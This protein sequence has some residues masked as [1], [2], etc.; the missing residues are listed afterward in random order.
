MALVAAACS[1]NGLDD[2]SERA[3]TS[4]PRTTEA[5]TSTTEA[6]PPLPPVAADSGFPADWQPARLKWSPCDED[7]DAECAT[8]AVPLDWSQP[9][10]AQIDLALARLPATGDRIGSL[11]SNPGGP[12]ASGIQY[13]L[14][15]PFGDALADRFDLVSWDPRGIGASTKLSCGD[16]VGGFL[17]LD[18]DPDNS[19]EQVRLDQAAAAVAA[20]CGA[21][22]A[23]L[24]PHLGTDEVARDLEAIRLALGDPRLN[25]IGFSYG[26]LIGLRYLDLFG[27]RARAMV[28]DGVVDPTEDLVDLLSGQSAAIDAAVERIFE[29]CGERSRCPMTDPAA[30]FDSLRTEVETTPLPADHEVGPAELGTAGIYSVYDPDLWQ[31]FLRAIDQGTEGDGDA[32]WELAEGYYDFGDFTA[33]AAITCQDS[34]HPTGAEAHAA[35]VASLKVSSPRFGGNIGNEMLPCAYWPTPIDDVTGPVTAEDSPDVVVL[36]N[37]GDAL[38]PYDDS[39]EVAEM[40][41]HGNLVTYHGEGHTSYGRDDCV[42][43]AVHAYFIDLLVPPTDPQCGQASSVA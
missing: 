26:T 17:E 11:L 8:L 15:Q 33:Y 40:L 18:P 13:L 43:R 42:D 20:E 12:G 16:E 29:S 30:S 34:P 1:G 7:E 27:E 14:S 9:A 39:V 25:Y 3:T 37:V 2:R 5:P 10:G 32:M 21:E 35:F 23:E 24:L 28:L 4:A 41:A 6:V 36:G 22:D 19:A 38:T 31:T